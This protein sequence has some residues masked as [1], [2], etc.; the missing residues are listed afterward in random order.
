MDN[1]GGFVHDS[2]SSLVSIGQLIFEP[3]S[4]MKS[5][6][7]TN[8]DQSRIDHA[9]LCG[10]VW[11][12]VVTCLDLIRWFTNSGQTTKVNKNLEKIFHVQQAS[13]LKDNSW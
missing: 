4:I 11:S 9:L 6:L 1:Q 3:I 8:S 10:G 7:R 5:V 13:R 2:L 12:V